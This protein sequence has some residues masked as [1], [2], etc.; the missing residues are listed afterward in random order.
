MTASQAQNLALKAR[1][2][3]SQPSIG[4]CLECLR[5]IGLVDRIGGRLVINGL[6]RV[7]GMFG[8]IFAMALLA[9][10]ETRG[11]NI[12]YDPPNFGAPDR[13]DAARTSYEVPLGPLDVLRISVYRVPELS[14]DYQVDARGMVDLPLLGPINV[15]DQHPDQFARSLETLYGE[16]YLQQPDI[17]VRV[18]N[19]NQ[20]NVTVE[21]GVNVPGIYALP[22]RTTLL[23]AVALARGVHPYESNAKRVAIFRKQ[24]G[25]TVAAAFDLTAIRHGEM[26]DPV[27]YPGDT[28]VVDGARVRSLFRDILQTIPVLAIF[29]TI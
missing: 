8:L 27:V 20:L 13:P 7:A 15:R 25:Q 3:G 19:T 16:R 2:T 29:R 11:G 10:C 9:G 17:T 12:P 1:A 23:G 26:E 5:R 24:D 22:G 21:G 14:S 4:H 28:I 6:R 18:L